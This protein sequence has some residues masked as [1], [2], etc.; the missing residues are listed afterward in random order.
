M[1]PPVSDR[2]SI[3][4]SATKSNQRLVMVLVIYLAFDSD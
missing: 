3:R 2:P 1:I 4:S